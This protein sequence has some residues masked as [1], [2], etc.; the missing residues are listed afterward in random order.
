LIGQWP[1]VV[2]KGDEKVDKGGEKVAPEEK[3]KEKENKKVGGHD[4]NKKKMVSPNVCRELGG[5]FD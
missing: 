3:K 1:S 2:D 4:S 5:T